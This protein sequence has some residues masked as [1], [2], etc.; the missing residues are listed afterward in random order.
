VYGKIELIHG[1]TSGCVSMEGIPGL[2]YLTAMQTAALTTE[3]NAL[4][5]VS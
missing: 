3:K 4:G 1:Q 2:V 5:T